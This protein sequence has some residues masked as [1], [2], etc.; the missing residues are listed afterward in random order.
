MLRAVL[1]GLLALGLSAFTYL[2]LERLGR[3][4][5]VP[6]LC[7][8]VAWASLGL[9]L[10]NLSCSVRGAPRRPLILLDASLSLDAVGARWKAARDSAFHWGEVRTFGDERL[11]L[12][13]VPQ[14]G[15]SL[16]TPALLAASAQDRPI[17]VVTDG[18]I[19]DWR[20]IPPDILSRTS[21]RLFARDTQPDLAITHVSGPSRVTAGDSIPLEVLVQPYGTLPSD[22]V[23][24]QVS[25]GGTRLVRR[26]L[27]LTGERGGR[28]RLTLPPRG[29]RAGDHILRV[30]LV[31]S[32]D[33]ESRTDS[34]LHLVTIVPTPGAV[35]LAGP[36]DWD[37]R[38][39]YRTLR[40]VSQLPVRGFV[41]LEASRWRSMT[42]LR[43]VATEQVRRAARQADLLILKGGVAAMEQGSRARGV[44]TWP[45]GEG[46]QA[47]IPGDWYLV[48]GE[49]SPLAGAFL[50]QPVDSFPPA[51][52]LN[53]VPADPGSWVA[54]SA[55]L[56][57]R[58]PARPAVLGYQS[59]RVRHVVVAADG[60]WR[61]AFRGGSSE[62]SYR[63]WVAAT[64]S[65]LLGGRETA[66]G[67]ARPLQPVVPNGRPVIFEWSGSGSPV[68]VRVVWSG[69]NQQQTDT[70]HFDG[71]GRATA[72]LSPGEY[73]YQLGGEGRSGSAGSVAVEEYSQELIPGQVTM[74]AREARAAVPRGHTSARDWLWLFALCILGLSGE[75]FARRRLGLR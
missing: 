23:L 9:L 57:R 75:W 69:S 66:Q 8:A 19:E 50:G 52:Q 25:A 16:L 1:I 40:D 74:V 64:A 58:G 2:R 47:R 33:R 38:F 44:W 22:T 65:W 18:E 45:S 28:A 31:R 70:L 55:Q 29:L 21:V 41:R 15:R 26:T 68:P 17:I 34:R 30:S 61:W 73:R 56:G 42:N 54:L 72:W 12:D 53:S 43:P 5:W 51:V 6:L 63:S 20:E 35:L 71:N 37:S 48:A 13:S 62:Q 3:R 4:A 7:R 60:L 59:G 46:G 11:T 32:G 14:R 36:P 10:I 67:L 49:T 39:L 27:R 24:L